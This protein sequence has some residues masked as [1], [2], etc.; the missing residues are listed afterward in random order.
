MSHDNDREDRGSWT[1]IWVIALA[2]AA[3]LL[4]VAWR[5]AGPPPPNVLRMATAG[6]GG[7]Y[8]AFGQRLERALD[9]Q[10]FDLV[11]R[12]SSGS[13]QNLA[14]LRDGHV[15]G[16]K[17]L[18]CKAGPRTPPIVSTW[19]HWRP[20]FLSPFGSSIERTNRSHTS[21]RCDGG[22]LRWGPRAAAPK[23]SHVAC[24]PGTGSARA[25]PRLCTRA[26]K[27]C[28]RHCKPVALTPRS[29]SRVR[30]CRMCAPCCKTRHL[31]CSH[32][33]AWEAY[34][35]RA[36]WLA[37]VVVPEGVLDLDTNVPGSRPASP[38]PHGVAGCA[39]GL[40]PGLDSAAP[41]SNDG[42]ASIRRRGWNRR[43]SFRPGSLQISQ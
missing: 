33:S 5:F 9:N 26:A 11:L 41:G 1:R 37:P 43:D 29:L 7:G 19:K 22:G 24:W 18:W 27:R 39:Q 25:T 23:R 10:S 20:C 42:R 32:R 28:R 21:R 17:W 31:L 12:P 36:R 16:C 40:A 13:V 30:P 38:G 34:R 35:T 14:W 15:T 4:Y 6:P 3:L 2:L 8:H